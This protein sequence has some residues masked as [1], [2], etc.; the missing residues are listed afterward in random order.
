MPDYTGF[1]DEV[2]P[3]QKH[4]M[5]LYDVWM[6]GLNILETYDKST[7]FYTERK[8]ELEAAI[9]LLYFYMS[10]DYEEPKST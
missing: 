4:L 5:E 9:K 10:Q 7:A 3:R 8:A 6:T 1:I 2:G